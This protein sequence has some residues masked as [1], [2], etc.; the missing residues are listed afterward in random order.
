MQAVRRNL[1][2]F[3]AFKNYHEITDLVNLLSDENGNLRSFA[4]F[5][6]AAESITASYGDR[7]LRVEYDTVVRNGE[8]AAQWQDYERDKD[9]FPSLQYMTQQDG[10]V[11]PAHQQMHG[12]IRAVDDPFWDSFYPPNG[13]NCR[14]YVLQSD[15]PAET[16]D[17]E[18]YEKEVPKIFRTN[19]G[20]NGVIFTDSHPYFEN[21]KGVY[22]SSIHRQLRNI[23]IDEE[24]YDVAFQ[25]DGLKVLQHITHDFD[26][27]KDNLEFV[28]SI[29]Q[30]SIIKLLPAGRIK[31]QK[32][33]DAMIDDQPL[34]IKKPTSYPVNNFGRNIL[35]KALIQFKNWK[36][37]GDHN[38][39]SL[40]I[41]L[42][43]KV[44]IEEIVKMKNEALSKASISKVIVLHVDDVLI[45]E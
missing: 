10:D 29:N 38:T 3:A 44:D 7:Y 16:G 33:I 31:G 6:K 5:K 22:P 13:W 12:I 30:G 41:H 2:T 18:K 35:K 37:R 23:L 26:E 11:R 19:T 14:C 21:I 36:H 9:I 39:F 24:I 43:Q 42:T 27:F 45:Y 4:E 15:E 34:E 17:F 1:L 25:R 28:K 20:K 32:F 8:M 40:G